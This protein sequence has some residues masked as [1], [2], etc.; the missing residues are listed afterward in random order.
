MESL[1]PYRSRHIWTHGSSGQAHRVQVDVEEDEGQREPAW[2]WRPLHRAPGCALRVSPFPY[3]TFKKRLKI[4]YSIIQEMVCGKLNN[5][6]M[7]CNL[8]W[9]LSVVFY[10]EEE[11]S[12]KILFSTNVN[13]QTNL[14]QSKLL[15]G[16]PPTSSPETWG[17]RKGYI[18]SIYL[19]PSAS[20]LPLALS[21][22]APSP[23]SSSTRSSSLKNFG[24][25]QGWSW[26]QESVSN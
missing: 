24:R 16:L 15:R 7:N 23:T 11:I 6:Q 3:F 18:H 19:N 22:A 4:L 9:S 25:D 26:S 8:N 21:Q 17:R 12:C 5:R 2:G 20:R 14:D 1:V 10:I 13:F